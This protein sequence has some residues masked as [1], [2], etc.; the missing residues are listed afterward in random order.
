MDVAFRECQARAAGSEAAS[1]GR[2]AGGEGG[3][4]VG[5]DT[6]SGF[7][8]GTGVDAGGS[9]EEIRQAFQDGNDDPDDP[10]A[11]RDP[12]AEAPEGLRELIEFAGCP[13]ALPAGI[14][15]GGKRGIQLDGRFP[16][17]VAD[18]FED[19]PGDG[20]FGG[21]PAQPLRDARAVLP[22]PP[23]GL[24]KAGA[25]PLDPE[26]DAAKPGARLS[27]PGADGVEPRGRL[28]VGDLVVRFGD[29]VS[30]MKVEAG[31]GRARVPEPVP[32]YSV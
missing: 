5:R 19:A 11:E 29:G 13:R 9:G 28:G 15:E 20:A 22:E 24:P 25:D 1:A 2:R 3:P 6:E 10:R 8:A 16:E 18:P 23:P 7:G 27:E 26:P 14:A 21:D 4:G 32:V 12:C 31:H 17:D 30:G